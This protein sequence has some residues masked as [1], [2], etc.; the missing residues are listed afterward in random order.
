MFTIY[1]KCPQRFSIINYWSIAFLLIYQWIWFLD[2]F[3]GVWTKTA[4]LSLLRP[5][6]RYAILCS[7]ER[8]A[9]SVK[10]PNGYF[11]CIYQM[12]CKQLIVCSHY[13]PSYPFLCCKVKATWNPFFL[14]TKLSLI[15][16]HRLLW[17]QCIFAVH[18][19]DEESGSFRKKEICI[20][21]S[22][23]CSKT[24]FPNKSTTSAVVRLHTTY[25]PVGRVAGLLFMNLKVRGPNHGQII[26]VRSPLK[27]VL[28]LW[29]IHLL[30]YLPIKNMEVWILIH[31]GDVP[32]ILH[33]SYFTLWYAYHLC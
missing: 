23:G 13:N 10:I 29:R 17:S 24:T 12:Q 7:A 26:L 20:S 15:R 5:P 19:K 1:S 2:D 32:H 16:V 31:A 18:L 3:L 22:K 28:G 25:G 8:Y 21:A 30:V 27:Q 6:P 14:F 33:Y 11:G 4:P 9:T